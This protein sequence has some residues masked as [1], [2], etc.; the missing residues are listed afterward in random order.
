MSAL[1]VQQR[2]Y[3]PEEYLALEREAEF[4]SEYFDGGIYAMSGGTPAHSQII[5][6]TSTAVSSQLWNSLCNG[7]NADLKVRAL[8]PR[9]LFTYPDFTI[10]CGEL[11]FHEGTNDVVINPQLI[12]EVLSPSTELFDRGAKFIA[13]QTLESL[14]DY[15]IVLQDRP[16]VEHHTRQAGG[17]W[18]MTPA[19]GLDAT[20]Y[21]ASIGCILELSKVYKGV[22]FPPRLQIRAENET[23]G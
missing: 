15:I 19:E 3:T 23:H 2:Y 5:N 8:L 13:Y 12:V 1:E 9:Q 20:L 16:R 10:V 14:T 18:L 6:N 21:I 22:T 4:K 7:H 17:A 11:Q